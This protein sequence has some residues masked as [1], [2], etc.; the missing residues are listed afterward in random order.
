MLTITHT[1]TEKDCYLVKRDIS[2]R[3]KSPAV[4]PIPPKITD[5][6]R[7]LFRWMFLAT[8]LLC[9]GFAPFQNDKSDRITLLGFGAFILLACFVLPRLLIWFIIAVESATYRLNT[10]YTLHWE[11]NETGIRQDVHFPWTTLMRYKFTDKG[12]FALVKRQTDSRRPALELSIEAF[13]TRAREIVEQYKQYKTDLGVPP[14][15]VPAFGR[16]YVRKYTGLYWLARIL[17]GFKPKQYLPD[18]K[19]GN[20]SI[21]DLGITT[22][23]RRQFGWERFKD[24][25]F[26]DAGLSLFVEPISPYKKFLTPK[27]RIP[28]AALADISIRSTLKKILNQRLRPSMKPVFPVTP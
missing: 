6:P 25:E 24:F 7:K 1:I 10:G 16:L 13:R 2:Q 27:L 11:I 18:P 20:W 12:I 23:S 22:A 15:S 9:L 8:G 28:A 3:V 5:A 17:S 26:N 21:N 19:D 4:Q 14:K